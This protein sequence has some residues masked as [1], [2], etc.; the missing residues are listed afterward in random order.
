ML[1]LAAH[2]ALI[3]ALA[4]G[5]HWRTSTPDVISAEIWAPVVQTRRTGT[6]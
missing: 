3:G 6:G 1:A 4:F 5:V 2:A